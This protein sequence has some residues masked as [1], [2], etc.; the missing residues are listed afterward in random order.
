MRRERAADPPCVKPFYT[1]ALDDWVHMEAS[2]LAQI[3]ADA[4]SI[5]NS[6]KVVDVARATFGARVSRHRERDTW[7]A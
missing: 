2:L 1:V 4:G 5:R 3:L 6:A 7:P